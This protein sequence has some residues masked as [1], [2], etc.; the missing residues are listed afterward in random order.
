M[1]KINANKSLNPRIIV[2]RIM[3]YAILITVV[4]VL[5]IPIYQTVVSGLKN[6]GEARSCSYCFPDPIRWENYATVLFGSA[7]P[8]FW[9]M[10]LNSMI[11]LVFTTVA[12]VLVCSLAAFIFSR[13]AFR[14]RDVL[15]NVLMIGLL[16][17]INAA[18]LPIFLT[19]RSL[20]LL[21]TLAGIILPQIA[22]GM[23]GTIIILRGFF[24]AIP[25]ELQDAASIDGCNTFDF[26]W[27]VM[28]PLTRPALA[29]VAALTAIGSWNSFFLPL[30]VLSKDT[31]YT[32]PLG[33]MQFQ[34]QYG[35][36]VALTQ[37]FIFLSLIPTVIFYLIAERQI[38]S[39][40][41]SGALK[42]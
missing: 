39:G 8:G 37:A 1:L 33:T 22:F 29:A 21:D 10:L 11:V 18:I 3:Q 28:L 41:T 19:I 16:F 36:D 38:V 2:T 30:L 13:T 12:V 9:T 5:F 14:G 25:S 17:P 23:A 34:G 42:G 15:F 4:T 32:L 31:L 35:S 6:N 40:L 24:R 26:F 27:R 7:K 20:N